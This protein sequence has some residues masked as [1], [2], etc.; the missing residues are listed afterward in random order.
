MSYT[1]ISS[2][3]TPASSRT[4]LRSDDMRKSTEALNKIAAMRSK[5]H[6]SSEN[7]RKSSDNLKIENTTPSRTRSISN[8]RCTQ[9]EPFGTFDADQ[10]TRISEDMVGPDLGS[11]ESPRSSINNAEWLTLL[12]EGAVCKQLVKHVQ[13]CLDQLQ[14][15]ADKTA[16]ARKLVE[17]SSLT[18]EQKLII[19]NQIERTTEKIIEKL[20]KGKRRSSAGDTNGNISNDYTPVRGPQIYTVLKENLSLHR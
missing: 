5:L 6:Q 11:D 13:E 2:R 3:I 1:A 7:L 15:N 10:Q 9:L 4:N 14:V 12:D 17:E 19:E 16:Q 8:L 20:D 18:A